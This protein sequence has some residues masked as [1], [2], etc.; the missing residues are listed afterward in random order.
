MNKEVL[1]TWLRKRGVSEATQT[2][3]N[4]HTDGVRIIIPVTDHNGSHVFNKYRR[5]PLDL[6][7]DG[8]KYY[9]DAGGKVQLYGLHQLLKSNARKVVVTEGELDCLLLWSH[10]IPAVSSTGGAGSWKTEFF[11]LLGERQIVV[12]FDNDRAGGEGM[13]RLYRERPDVQLV[14][15]PDDVGIK[16][17]TDY[18]SHGFDVRALIETAVTLETIDEVEEDRRIRTARLERVHFHNAVLTLPKKRVEY[19]PRAV[20]DRIEKAK[21]VKIPSITTMFSKEYKTLCPYHAE[22]TPSFTY[23]PR[24]NTCFCFGCR[25]FADAID[26]YRLEHPHESFPDV[27]TNL[28]RLV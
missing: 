2:Q 4:I 26:I 19:T 24:T 17:L 10:N 3:F 11:D 5:S 1:S 21:Q 12:A 7:E 27:I 28:N 22:N 8:K 6:K 16:D 15:V 23:F 14:F 25:K 13:A 20:D 9:Y 18:H